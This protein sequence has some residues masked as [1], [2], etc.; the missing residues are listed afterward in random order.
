MKKR[1]IYIMMATAI[2][3]TSLAGSTV[4]IGK[5]NVYAATQSNIQVK[6]NKTTLSLYKTDDAAQSVR[7]TA[8]VTGSKSGVKWS[9]SNKDVVKVSSSGKVTAVSNGTAVITATSKSDENAIATCK[10]SVKKPTKK[11]TAQKK[12]VRVN[13][14]NNYMFN[15]LKIT[16]YSQ[17]KKVINNYEKKAT[18]PNK[19]VLN[20]LKGYKQSYF[21]K[22]ALLLNTMPEYP[23][24]EVSVGNVTKQLSNNGKFQ[25]AVDLNVKFIGR[26]DVLYPTGITYNDCCFIEISKELSDNCGKIVYFENRVK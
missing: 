22:K 7:L 19:K 20:Q 13:G 6:L 4:F 25:I 15:N 26:E 10:V 3:V 1:I 9:S 5:Q 23:G 24:Y 17:L 18:S 2:A 16:S 12:V 14:S 21:N 8:T 11:V